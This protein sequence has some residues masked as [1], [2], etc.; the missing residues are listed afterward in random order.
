M[1]QV[2]LLYGGNSTEHFISLKTGSFIFQTLNKQ[3]YKVK[4]ILITEKGLWLIPKN[5]S[6]SIPSLSVND[7]SAVYEKKFR[8]Q[9]IEEFY[10]PNRLDCEVVFL[11]LHGGNGENG[12]I[13]AYLEL[14][15]VPYT[16]S[17]VL[18]SALAMDKEKSNLVYK[19]SGLNVENF[20]VFSKQ[21]LHLLTE[22]QIQE[23]LFQFGIHFPCF[24]KPNH[25]GSSV[26]AG[27]ARNLQELQIRLQ[28]VFELENK[29]FVQNLLKGI[30]VSCGVIEFK[31]G[32]S[33]Q[34]RPLYPTQIL[35]KSEF[36]DFEAK[37]KTGGSEEITPAPISL[38]LTQRVREMSL[39]AHNVLGCSGYSRTDFIIQNN[40]PYVLE[41]NTLPGMTETSLIPQQA[42]YE[43]IEMEYLLD[44]LIENALSYK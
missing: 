13:Q 35:P 9:E 2:Y 29:A 28:N 7:N 11:G 33:F 10:L 37:Y 34:P 15:G 4:P 17:K 30:E 41:T 19:A 40:I 39:L 5:Y 38:E 42:H 43:K 23:K 3:K 44:L 22:T 14:L 31:E 24:V 20:V 25:G 8:Q 12:T 1:L 27:I 21:E 32:E 36:F 6:H 26:G 16:G 18:A